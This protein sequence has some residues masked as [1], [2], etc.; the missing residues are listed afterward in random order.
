MFSNTGGKAI[1]DVSAGENTPSAIRSFVENGRLKSTYD[2]LE[3]G[4]DTTTTTR[5]GNGDVVIVLDDAACSIPP[6]GSDDHGREAF[7]PDDDP[8]FGL[9]GVDGLMSMPN[10]KTILVLGCIVQVTI[11]KRAADR[12]LTLQCLLGCVSTMTGKGKLFNDASHTLNGTTPLFPRLG[13]SL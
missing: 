12:A 9:W 5:E 6:T 4:T 11:L 8:K 2:L 10:V 3:G 7:A 13:R 1:P